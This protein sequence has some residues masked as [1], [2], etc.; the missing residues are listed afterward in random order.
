MRYLSSPLRHLHPNSSIYAKRLT[1]YVVA[2]VS[3]TSIHS[4]RYFDEPQ[5]TI[6]SRSPQT[7]SAPFTD[8]VLDPRA[9]EERQNRARSG[10]P[11]ILRVDAAA[12]QA[13]RDQLQALLAQ[14][15]GLRQQAGVVLFLEMDRLSLNAQVGLRRLAPE[16]WA[17]LKTQI[18]SAPG[19]LTVVPDTF[20]LAPGIPDELIQAWQAA[21][22][23]QNPQFR[24]FRDPLP[25]D[26][27]LLRQIEQAQSRYQEVRQIWDLELNILSPLLLDLTQE[28]WLMVQQASRRAL[29]RMQAVGLS[30]GLP[31]ALRLQGIQIQFEDMVL[32]GIVIQENQAAIRTAMT[33]LLDQVVRPNLLVDRDLT[34]AQVDL[35][36]GAV[37]PAL[38]PVEAGQPIAR[39][40]Q[41]I[42]PEIF[43][44]LD[45][46]ELTQRG[47]NIWGILG[48][49]GLMS[50]VLILAIPVQER[51]YPRLRAR[52]RMLTLLLVSTVA[53]LA[54]A[55]GIQFSS[56]PAVGLLVS[57]FFGTGL[58][59]LVVAA[60]A[61]LLPLV[62][63]ATVITWI[64]LVAGSLVACIGARRLRSREELALLGGGAALTQ[65]VVQGSLSLVLGNGLGWLGIALAGGM[66]L[67]WSIIA[68]GAS[69][70]LERL[71][72]LVTPVRLLELSN[73]NRLLLRRLAT[74][75]PGTFQHTLFVTT[76]AERAAQRLNLNAE[77][78]RAGTLYHDIGKML[79]AQYFIEN[80]MGGPNPHTALNDPYRSAQIIK[81]HVSD[82]LK[83]ARQYHLPTALR[84]FI[85]EHQGT[86]RIAYFHHQ[87]QQ[88]ADGQP[89]PEEAFRYD[90]PIP[91]TPETGVVMLADACEAA[92][93]SM[94]A[95]EVPD[96]DVAA[97]AR[98]TVQRIFRSRWEDG[99]LLDSNLTL[100]D[101]DIVA[102]AFLEVWRQSNHERIP[103]PKAALQGPGSSAETPGIGRTMDSMGG[104]PEPIPSFMRIRS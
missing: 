87:A 60:Q 68:L 99:Q 91:Q 44:I 33:Q 41:E 1:G 18:Q 79:Q 7:I 38:I 51:L 16:S 65:M 92:L 4:L 36:V 9:T 46:Y 94:I 86:I 55:F 24:A 37:Q 29:N 35:A 61:L 62:A 78:V 32:P 11:D 69:P 104:K 88:Q 80:Q 58:G 27:P 49:G 89:V 82:G 83:M 95:K 15:E 54:S 12:N 50:I 97:E 90:G 43:L 77:L 84:A 71:F 23:Q 48:V 96:G 76:L 39:A 3:L 45:H 73:P 102:E 42:T 13:M 47:I 101:L 67:G 57:S 85:P 10:T 2:L 17:A 53:P 21:A 14:I 70:Y 52:D 26:L 64:P 6:G 63:E 19:A 31:A 103:Y 34:R 100:A 81:A 40:G 98:A 8:Q 74:E 20:D 25:G 93:R 72:D 30:P 56:L 66:G 59:V 22:R 75:A 28:E 5:L